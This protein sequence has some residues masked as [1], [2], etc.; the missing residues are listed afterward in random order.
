[1]G[2]WGVVNFAGSGRGADT[3]DLELHGGGKG[4]GPAGQETHAAAGPD[5]SFLASDGQAPGVEDL[6]GYAEFIVKGMNWNPAEREVQPRLTVN[7]LC[8]F[9]AS[10]LEWVVVSIVPDIE[11]HPH[12]GAL[13][14]RSD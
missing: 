4:A 7:R 10:R 2:G 1:M 3:A 14:S 6:K 9:W 12:L 11:N 13:S 8:L 5:V